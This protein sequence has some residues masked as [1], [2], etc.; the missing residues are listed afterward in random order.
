[1]K[2]LHVDVFSVDK[3]YVEGRDCESTQSG[4][5]HF[6]KIKILNLSTKSR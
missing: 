3:N 2:Q 5:K 1:M 6:K 4:Q